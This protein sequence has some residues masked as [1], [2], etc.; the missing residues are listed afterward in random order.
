MSLLDG[1]VRAVDRSSG[2][3]LWTFSSGGPLVQAHRSVS[4]GPDGGGTALPG[5]HRF[6]LPATPRRFFSLRPFS[7]ADAVELLFHG[8]RRLLHAVR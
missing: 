6:G 1:T 3:T 5:T 4:D 8:S 2:E 7:N